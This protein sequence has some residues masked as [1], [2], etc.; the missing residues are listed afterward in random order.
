MNHAP[1]DGNDS[2]SLLLLLPHSRSAFPGS[3]SQNDQTD[4]GKYDQDEKHRVRARIATEMVPSN[5]RCE[6]ADAPQKD[7]RQTE[8]CDALKILL[9]E[10]LR[11]DRWEKRIKAPDR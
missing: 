8:T 5:A 2:S 10:T 11:H 9:A 7:K 4:D 6:G 3:R 1:N